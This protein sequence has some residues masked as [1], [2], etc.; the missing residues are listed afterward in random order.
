MMVKKLLTK[1]NLIILKS[2]FVFIPL[3]SVVALSH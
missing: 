1:N 2:T 3:D